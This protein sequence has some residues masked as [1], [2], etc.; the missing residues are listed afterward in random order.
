MT[1][2]VSKTHI[3]EEIRR[4][5]SANGGVPLGS[6]RFS[7]ETGIRKGE[8]YGRFWSSWGQ[9]VCEA[10]LSPNRFQGPSDLERL[11]ECFAEL[12]RKLGRIPTSGDLKVARNENADVPA[13]STFASLG[14]QVDRVSK[15][16]TWC[17]DRLGF[18]AVVDL[19]EEYL[20]RKSVPKSTM[21]EQ[22]ESPEGFVYLFK[23][24]QYYKIGMTN[25][26]GRREYEL[27]IQLP[28][29]LKKVH[30]IR[31]DD[32][33]GIEKYW[34]ERFAKKRKNGEWFEL[35]PND[36]KSFKRRKSM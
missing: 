8:W 9:A 15:M 27:S 23:W 26:V 10:G 35:D 4:T 21:R 24:G 25:H 7:L 1:M 2:Q 13:H 11:I 36:V 30:E 18:E 34:H 17:Q 5:A 14:R 19:C 16:R 28:E 6:Q 32:P 31:T 3:I 20:A 22:A 33:Q 29:K 12:A